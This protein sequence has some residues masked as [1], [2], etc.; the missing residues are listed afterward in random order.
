[1]VQPDSR[2][3]DDKPRRVVY[4]C[5]LESFKQLLH[6]PS[7]TEVA[8]SVEDWVHAVSPSESPC[9]SCAEHKP[10]APTSP[11]VSSCVTRPQQ[12]PPPR[13]PLR[14]R[15][16]NQASKPA[17][18]SLKRKMSS[19]HITDPLHN[20][21][22]SRQRTNRE[23][24]SQDLAKPPT[25]KGRS[26]TTTRGRDSEDTDEKEIYEQGIDAA[27]ED[28]DEEYLPVQTPRGQRRDRSK[29]IPQNH[30]RTPTRRAGSKTTP[31]S[32]SAQEGYTEAQ[33]FRPDAENEHEDTTPNPTQRV[34]KRVQQR[35]KSESDF[36]P[37]AM[38]LHPPAHSLPTAP[39]S[40][41]KS[42]SSRAMG[43]DST[44]PSKKSSNKGLPTINRRSEMAHMTPPVEFI[45]P[46]DWR[47][48]GPVSDDVKNFW[49]NHI[50]AAGQKEHVIP[51]ELKVCT[52]GLVM[53]ILLTLQ[54]TRS[55]CSEQQT[56]Q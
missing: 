28:D 12:Q 32:K 53:F 20:P 19:D 17:Y 16:N 49:V 48:I 13:Y 8:S 35:Q 46:E 10:D 43:T 54:L 51:W 39:S 52:C 44:S 1:M 38:P 56:H 25:R 30:A 55:A 26:K 24:P 4:A 36:P 22:T 11:Q 23:N 41:T 6:D 45:A 21:S 7:P 42:R 29:V 15:N 33:E 50:R 34:P 3:I 27:H 40:P 47:D 37:T 14:P 31:K 5:T 2:R 18:P 9:G